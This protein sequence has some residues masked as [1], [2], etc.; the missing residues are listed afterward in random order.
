MADLVAVPHL[1]GV[2]PR[3]GGAVLEALVYEELQR[4]DGTERYP[5]LMG[6]GQVAGVLA[7]MCSGAVAAP[8]IAASGFTA[9]GAASVA[10]CLLASLVATLFPEHRIRPTR[11]DTGRR[12]AGT[13]TPRC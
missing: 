6:R 13:N 3:I 2:Q 5:T 7:A 10:V 8:V 4:V 11:D 12:W 1:V 9:A